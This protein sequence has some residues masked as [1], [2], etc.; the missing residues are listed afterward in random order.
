[1]TDPERCAEVEGLI[2]EVALGVATAQDRARVLAH[3]ATCTG[4]RDLLAD[5]AEVTDETLA[6][7]SVREPPAGFE[8]QV[9][10]RLRT[11]GRWRARLRRLALG[12]AAVVVAAALSAGAVYWADQAD[13]HL[14]EQVRS[15]LATAHGQYF[16]AI[17]LR[18][19]AGMRRGALF[20]YQG[21]PAWVFLTVTGRLAP[22][23]YA[24]EIVTRGGDPYR[25]ADGLDL[26]GTRSW[27]ATIPVA[28]HE[29][30]ILRV[31]RDGRLV[32]SAR[33]TAP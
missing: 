9:L 1:M 31:T 32:F 16:T 19:V 18:D 25:L 11:T 4:C 28:V 24:I 33:I 12:T 29:I 10:A 17:P 22:G 23:R 8:S 2:P 15:T 21:E 30:S 3:V 13:R 20:A 14:A 7:G 26:P 27:G 5:L 6:L